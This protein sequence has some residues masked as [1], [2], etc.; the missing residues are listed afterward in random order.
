MKET[1]VVEWDKQYTS[2]KPIKLEYSSIE[3]QRLILE[4]LELSHRNEL[5][6]LIDPK[7]WLWYTIPIYNSEDMDSYIKRHLADQ[8]SGSGLTYVVR[9]KDT[10]K[11]VGSSRFCNIDKANKRVE[12]GSTWYSPKWQRTFVNTECKLVMLT[13]AFEHLG[14]ICVQ[15]QTDSLNE[16]SRAAIQRIGAKPDGI[17]RNHRICHD[18]R[19]R[20]SAFYSITEAEWPKVK[21]HIANLLSYPILQS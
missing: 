1:F 5:C 11:I 18:G 6:E 16:K 10:D 7:I 15:F 12:I 14:C 9:L 20:H 8:E 13:Y 17:L 4:P 19:I 21:Q 3:G 2:L